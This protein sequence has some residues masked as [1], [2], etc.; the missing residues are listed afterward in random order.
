M[1]CYRWISM[2][3]ACLLL[4][5]APAEQL[6]VS[7]DVDNVPPEATS[8]G[9]SATADVRP[10]S[11]NEPGSETEMSLP[12]TDAEW[13]EILTEEQFYVTRNEG[14]RAFTRRSRIAGS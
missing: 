8:G 10:A 12:K 7:V 2:L 3:A 9:D 1:P 5:C 11:A 4:G 13:K 14:A 6:S